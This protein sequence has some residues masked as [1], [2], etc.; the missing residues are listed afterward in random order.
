M[1]S[2]VE[3]SYKSL[4]SPVLEFGGELVPVPA[5]KGEK[6]KRTRTRTM[7]MYEMHEGEHKN[8]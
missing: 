2:Q 3:N 5:E 1:L 8:V 4:Q 6:V 7:E